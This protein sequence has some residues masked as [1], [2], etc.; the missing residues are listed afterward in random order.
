[1]DTSAHIRPKGE[2]KRVSVL[3]KKLHKSQIQ[4]CEEAQKKYASVP[5]K[6]E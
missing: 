5:Q 6:K 2:K 3:K 4:T 1:M